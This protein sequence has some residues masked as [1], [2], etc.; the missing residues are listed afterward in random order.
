MLILLQ[1]LTEQRDLIHDVL[2][3][4]LIELTLE[5]ICL[6]AVLGISDL[7]EIA[8]H[9]V[10]D[11]DGFIEISLILVTLHEQRVIAGLQLIVAGSLITGTAGHHERES[12]RD[13]CY[14][15]DK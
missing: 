10:D 12:H 13:P 4:R 11:A 3:L 2:L 15:L 1:G 14:G 8:L 9:L 6:H 7:I 5:G